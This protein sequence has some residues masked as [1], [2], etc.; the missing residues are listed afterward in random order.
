MSKGLKISFIVLGIS[1]SVM[2]FNLSTK[3]LNDSPKI[4]DTK[5]I[6][7]A[8]VINTQDSDFIVKVL[9]NGASFNEG[10]LVI[11]KSPNGSNDFYK[12]GENV[13][14]TFNGY[15]YFSYPYQIDAKKIELIKK[16]S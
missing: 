16:T 14:I 12:V 10:D 6:L 3:I 11:V 2:I 7:V 13:S 4:Q 15:V 5:D 8:K 1:I 9:K